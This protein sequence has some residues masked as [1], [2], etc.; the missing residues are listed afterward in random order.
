MHFP[1]CLDC[2]SS[3][4]NQLGDV[5]PLCFSGDPLPLCWD[6][7]N[8][9]GAPA[10]WIRNRITHPA[11]MTQQIYPPISMFHCSFADVSQFGAWLS[12]KLKAIAKP[13]L[14]S[15]VPFSFDNMKM[16]Q[17][18][19]KKKK[20]K[21]KVK[22]HLNILHIQFSSRKERRGTQPC[23]VLAHITLREASKVTSIVA[24]CA[25]LLWHGHVEAAAV[26]C[27]TLLGRCL[28]PAAARAVLLGCFFCLS[29]AE[30][31]L[32]EVGGGIWLSHNKVNALTEGAKK[33]KKCILSDLKTPA[34]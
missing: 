11:A 12:Q 1:V 30:M 16:G 21:K 5:I 13:V 3:H 2:E 20:S 22:P 29:A 28:D 24:M 6:H 17:C 34:D 10:S 33:K 8:L 31:L 15:E 19:K 7:H 14:W 26:A 25:M 18:I 23:Q 4:Q 32:L 9:L 27:S